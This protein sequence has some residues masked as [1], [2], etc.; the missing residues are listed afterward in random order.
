MEV[1]SKIRAL[2]TVCF[3]KEKRERKSS[4]KGWMETVYHKSISTVQYTILEKL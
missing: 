3:G 2:S 1:T 4:M